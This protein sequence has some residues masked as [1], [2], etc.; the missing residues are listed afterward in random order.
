MFEQE[1]QG[2]KNQLIED[3]LGCVAINSVRSDPEPDAPFGPGPKRA[4]EYTL[5]LAESMGL[6]TCSL[7]HMIGYAEYGEGEE[8]IGVL[9]HLDVVPLGDGWDYNPLGELCADRI[10]GR[11]TL[12]D[13]G[14][15]IGALYALKAIKESGVSL[16]RRIRLIFGTNEESGDADVD[17]YKETE[18]FPTMGFTPDADYPVI[19]SEKGLACF[20]VECS[21]SSGVLRAAKAGEAVNQVPDVASAELGFEDGTKKRL[22]SRGKAAHASTPWEGEN[23]IA[24]LMEQLAACELPEDLKAF[25]DFFNTC[26]GR[27]TDGHGLD[28]GWDGGKFGSVTVNAGLLEGD[29]NHIALWFDCRYP[30]GMDFQEAFAKVKRKAAARGLDAELER[31]EQPLYVPEDSVLVQTLQRIYQEQTQTAAEPI[32][33][34]GG[35]YAKAMEHIVAFG[36]VFPGQENVIHQKN[37]YISIPNLLKN[38][39]IMAQAMYE[40]ANV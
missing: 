9:G 17:R 29:E 18:E 31:L 28:I 33:I 40:L 39:Q 8:M 5:S 21:L 37:E 26:A 36:P 14:P 23:A 19:F 22:E 15:M 35:T 38:T 11:G 1:I 34:G 4:L 12:D 27:G 32:V 25:V 2:Y 7:D 13:K 30:Y 6:R 16:K 20:R 10:Y 24:N 3:L